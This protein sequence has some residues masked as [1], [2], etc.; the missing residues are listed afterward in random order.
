MPLHFTGWPAVMMEGRTSSTP[1]KEIPSSA[2]PSTT[3]PAAPIRSV[4]PVS[5]SA[6]DAP[7]VSAC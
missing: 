6:N 1:T 5:V 4:S 2:T 3:F 7:A